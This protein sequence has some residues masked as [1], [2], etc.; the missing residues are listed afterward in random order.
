MRLVAFPIDEEPLDLVSTKVIRDFLYMFYKGLG[1]EDPSKDPDFL[2][3]C[4]RLQGD[5]LQLQPVTLMLDNSIV[6]Q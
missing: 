3:M 2:E 1:I 4:S 5:A 6:P